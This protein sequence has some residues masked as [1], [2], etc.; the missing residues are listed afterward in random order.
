MD[1]AEIEQLFGGDWE[2]TIKMVPILSQDVL[3]EIAGFD[4][5]YMIQIQ[6]NDTTFRNIILQFDKVLQEL[7]AT[8]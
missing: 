8:F 4:E 5:F 1:D 3:A 6:Q 2:S 7:I